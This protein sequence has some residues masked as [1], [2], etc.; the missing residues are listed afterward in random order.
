[1]GSKVG[2]WRRQLA[3]AFEPACIVQL[4]Q[5]E[6]L[7]RR[8][9]LVQN[10][11]AFLPNSQL[12][13]SFVYSRAQY[14]LEEN[15]PG[16]YIDSYMLVGSVTKPEDI[17][18]IG[19]LVDLV[20]LRLDYFEIESKPKF[21]CIFTLRKKEQGGVKAIDEQERL[22]KIEK[23]LELGPEYL[24]IEA[25]TDPG[26]I[27]RIA[28]T[29][30]KV[31]IIGSYHNFNET[32][33][34]L[35]AILKKMQNRRFAIYKMALKANSTPDMLR[36]MLFAGK[37]KEPLS[38]MSMGEFGKP[39]RVLGK[40]MGSCL[41]Y[42]G[43]DEEF[44][45]QRYDIKTLLETF[46]YKKLNK[47]T[48]IFALIGD[49]IEK[50]PSHIFH[51]TRFRHNA[52]YIKMVV[53]P[54]EVAETF[55]LLKKLPFG[56]LSV[57]IPLKELVQE[58]MDVIKPIAKA[59]GAI[60]TVIF[61]KR[62]VVGTNTDAPG[63]L[64]AIEKHMKV[65]GKKIA[66]LGAG[67]AARAIIYEA[68]QRGAHVEIFNR[69]FE[70]AQTLANE[71]NCKAFGINTFPNHPYDLLINT[72]PPTSTYMPPILPGTVVMDVVIVPK[73]TPLLIEAK[74]QGNKCIYGEEMFIEQGLL[75]QKEWKPHKVR[76]G[77]AIG[78]ILI[79]ILGLF[80]PI[81]PGIVP[82]IFGLYLINPNWVKGKIC[83]WI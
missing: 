7:R 28:K 21:P 33:S 72:T 83:K 12:L 3:T 50:S 24:D 23:L 42:T 43:I 80:L 59:I 18:Q 41:D 47:K 39:S 25:D 19:P 76:L 38:I 11:G 75:Q 6:L 69:T 58:Q 8:Q 62:K 17:Q 60:N 73:E 30:P 74:K 36:L 78:L 71:F 45:L 79:G 13:N 32:P 9:S 22:Y 70:R 10:R 5:V 57:T 20:E 63:A 31:K 49:P 16:N 40:I 1:M 68:L 66:I 77:F 37:T 2:F 44:E 34:D 48:R 81:L 82:I 15:D 27:E 46:H 14:M 54:H 65:K 4:I 29:F 61:K 55:S 53:R 52:V 26:F 56:G 64:N 67:G 35:D 51:N